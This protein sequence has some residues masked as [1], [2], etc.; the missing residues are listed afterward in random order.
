MLDIVDCLKK[1][2]Y[3]LC[4]RC[5][6]RDFYYLNKLGL[7]ANTPVT[8]KAHHGGAINRHLLPSTII[9][10][11]YINRYFEDLEHGFF[12]GICSCFISYIIN[13]NID[14]STWSSIILHDFLKCNNYP[15]DIHDSHLQIYYN[16][17]DPITFKH[18]KSN[19]SLT[20]EPLLLADRIELMRYAD[21]LDWV[22]ERFFS[23]Y[24]ALPVE[25]RLKINHFYDHIRPILYYFYSN[26]SSTFIRHGYEKSRPPFDHNG[27][28]PPLH[29]WGKKQ[30][31]LYPIEIDVAPF[32]SEVAYVN[33]IAM[34]PTHIHKRV[35]RQRSRNNAYQKDSHCSNHGEAALWNRIKGY[36]ALEHFQSLGGYIQGINIRDH[37]MAG[38]QIK[39]NQWRFISY[40][41]TEE[42]KLIVRYLNKRNIFPL[43]HTILY[44]FFMVYQLLKNRLLALNL[45]PPIY[46]K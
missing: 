40:N 15:Q 26:R 19:Q 4:S 16:N 9:P 13:S 1:I 36:I 17:L 37:L 27:C 3:D 5:A 2:K 10:D 8:G 11:E 39:L 28:F 29:Y 45:A 25:T 41:A 34:S 7:T 12:H 24:N 30:Y 46:Y 32:Y 21:Y 23:N 22:D 38:S 18:S 14:P 33:A 20:N 43:E 42:D 35:R 44:E 6:S 31:S